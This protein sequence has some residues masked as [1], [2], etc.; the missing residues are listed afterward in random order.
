M[1]DAIKHEC[2]IALIR[3][4]KPL[5]YYIEKYGTPLYPIN[6]MYILME[7]QSNRGQDGAGLANVK[8]DVPAGNRYISRYRSVENRPIVDIF[9]RVNEKYRSVLKSDPDKFTDADWL[10]KNLAFTGEVWL[11]HLRYGTHGK[12]EIENCHPMLRQSNWRSR[13]L[14]CA[15]NF[16]MTNADELFRKL[17]TLGQHPKDQG[18]TVTVMEKIGH[19]LD[20]ENQRV[21]ERFKGI[22]DNPALSDIIEDNMDLQRVL[23]RAC[24]D[25]DG[26]YALAGITG[27]GSSFVVRDPAGIRPAYYWAD[28]EVVVVASERPPLKAAFGA[29]FEDIKE[30][31]PGNAVLIDKYGEYGEFNIIEPTERKACS[32]ERIYFSRGAD[33]EIYQERKQLGKLLVPQILEEID[34]DLEN[35]I[36]SYIPN[37][38]E[39]S[40]FGLMEG[41]EEHLTKW[42]KEQL[43][44]NDISDERIEKILNFKPRFEKLVSKDVKLR[45]FITNDNDRGEMVSHVYEMTQGVVRKGKDTIVVID[46][47]IVRGTT[48][49]KSIL[50]LLDKLEPK[51]IVVVSS[52]PQ[53]RYPDCY[54]ID[55]SK[56][57]EFVAY[58]AMLAL[59]K[60]KGLEYMKEEVYNETMRSFS[61]KKAHKKNFVQTLYNTFDYHEVSAKIAEILKPEDLKAELAVIYQTVENLHKACPK[62]LGDWYFTGN[63]PTK[64]GNKV[65][66]K[67]FINFMEGKEVRAY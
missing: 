65:V 62:N 47:S 32:F 24:R 28:D 60:E 59:L 51:K 10:Q 9:S 2:G 39:A 44:G 56:V 35:T 53:I 8:I 40:F 21:F 16:N 17:V 5:D 61:N 26:G 18:D 3:L 12:N 13:N 57:K 29:K 30:L 38:A 31:Q 27:Y 36:F 45:T 54:G 1:S 50:K 49:E 22:Y 52:A 43:K 7:K 58:R 25:F 11:G 34:H 67:A 37:T 46:D 55:M 20:E 4:R 19:F 42:R 23:H 6:K 33:D 41:M 63:Y 66:N 64:G 48:L 15:G 14:V